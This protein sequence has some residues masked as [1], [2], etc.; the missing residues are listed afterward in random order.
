VLEPRVAT[1]VRLPGQK[2]E[3]CVRGVKEVQ[4]HFETGSLAR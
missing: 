3:G 4:R 1:H 2:S